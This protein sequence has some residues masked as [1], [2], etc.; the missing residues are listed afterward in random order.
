M[1]RVFL[2]LF[3]RTR[4]RFLA[5]AAFLLSCGGGCWVRLRGGGRRR[6]V[7]NG[8]VAL[9]LVQEGLILLARTIIV[10]SQEGDGGKVFGAHGHPNLACV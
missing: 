1:P 4:R 5:A 3:A 2:L 8:V 10:H 6:L 9:A 7:V